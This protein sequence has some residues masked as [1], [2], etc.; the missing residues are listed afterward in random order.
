MRWE[1]EERERRLEATRETV[2]GRGGEEEGKRRGRGGSSTVRGRG[3]EG[4]RRVQPRSR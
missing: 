4:K 1:E 2:R 3:G